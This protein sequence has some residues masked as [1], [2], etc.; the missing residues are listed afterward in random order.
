MMPGAMNGVGMAREIALRRPGIP[1]LLTS[2]NAE[3]VTA[4]GGAAGVSVLRKPYRINDLAKAFALALSNQAP[5]ARR[6]NS[7]LTV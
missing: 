4:G 2:G 1:I 5:L 7:A 6:P 3:A